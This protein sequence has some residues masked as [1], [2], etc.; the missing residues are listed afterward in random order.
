[1]IES[2]TTGDGDH[3]FGPA[4]RPCVGIMVIN[5]HGRLFAGRRAGM[6]D[7]GHVWQMP[8]GG[9]DHGETPE[10]AAWRELREETSIHRAALV[11]A[12]ANWLKYD[13]PRQ[14]R[15]RWQ[16]RFTG[17]AQRWYAFRFLGRDDEI[18]LNACGDAEFSHWCWQE[19]HEILRSVVPF[20]RA[21]YEA[22]I[23]EFRPLLIPPSGSSPGLPP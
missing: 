10:Q 13:F 11:G 3:P 19:P 16:G 20:K 6:E 4:Y 12:S 5:G 1:M 17:Q 21:V 14:A 7:T 15:H 22:V 2:V 8:Q 18:D 9:I 23:D